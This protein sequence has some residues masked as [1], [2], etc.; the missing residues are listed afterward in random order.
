MVA[1]V[2]DF[3]ALTCLSVWTWLLRETAVAAVPQVGLARLE[4]ILAGQRDWAYL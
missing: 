1:A 3:F 2:A 4:M